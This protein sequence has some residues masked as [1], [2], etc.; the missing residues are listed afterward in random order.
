MGEYQND[1]K[2]SETV[3]ESFL[4]MKN[5]IGYAPASQM[6]Q[7][8]ITGVYTGKEKKKDHIDEDFLGREV[9]F[10]FQDGSGIHYDQDENTFTVISPVDMKIVLGEND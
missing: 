1:Q 9:I 2:T 8:M 10:E 4:R 6:F 7:R 5:R 3:A